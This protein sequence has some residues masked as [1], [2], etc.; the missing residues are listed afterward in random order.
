MR[1]SFIHFCFG[2]SSS[3][4]TTAGTTLADLLDRSVGIGYLGGSTILLLLL[5][6]T[7]FLWHRSLGAVSIKS[8]DSRKAEV[9]YWATIMFSQTLGTALGDWMAD[10]KAGLGLGYQGGAIVFAVG[11]ALVAAGVFLDPHFAYGAVLGR[12]HPD[13]AP[14]VRQS[15]ITWTNRSPVAAWR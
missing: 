11:L 1:K 3:R 5:L 7:L 6:G 9:F 12:L 4:T 10:D 13:T 8:I 15:V 14:W 2:A